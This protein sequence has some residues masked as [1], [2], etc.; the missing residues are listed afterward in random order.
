MKAEMSR[1][2]VRLDTRSLATAV[3]RAIGLK[4]PDFAHYY[5]LQIKRP[6]DATDE[7]LIEITEGDGDDN[8]NR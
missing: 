4:G 7:W 5:V 8:S 1:L 3:M 2:S 6:G